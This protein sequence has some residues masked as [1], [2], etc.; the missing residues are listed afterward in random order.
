MTTSREAA[1]A[2]ERALLRGFDVYDQAVDVVSVFEWLH[3]ETASVP[4]TVRHFERYPSVAADDGKAA[5]PDFT[6]LFTAGAAIAGEIARFGL[7]EESVDG[8]CAQLLRYDALGGVPDAGG[9]TARADV[10]VVYLVEME[11][12]YP[13]LQR[14]LHDRLADPG[15]WYKPRRAPV[16][17]Q[18]ARTPER[19]VFQRLR[20][21]LN[22]RLRDDGRSPSVGEFLDEQSLK[23]PPA[24]F[25]A[26]KARRAFVNDSMDALY[27][28]THLWA[29]TFPT[30][31]GRPTGQAVTVHEKDLAGALREQF[32]L[33]KRADVAQ[34]LAL[35]DRAGLAAGGDARG[36]WNVAWRKITTART[37]DLHRVLAA[38][39]SGASRAARAI[40]AKRRDGP[41]PE[42]LSL[43]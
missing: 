23:V 40:P 34:A 36:E 1:A 18:Y 7:R 38:R 19:Y 17:V 12:G 37:G 22:G 39:A 33:G 15:H 16:I 28:A 6:V 43:L 42:Q 11:L 31:F 35:L 8:L 41:P 30:L 3:T 10:D 9:R 29:K 25:A 24:H 4:S 14:V 32:G 5:T 20:D 27:L 21:P 13:A 2:A 26:V